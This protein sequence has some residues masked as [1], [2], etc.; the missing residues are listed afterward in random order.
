[1]KLSIVAMEIARHTFRLRGVDHEGRA[2]RRRQVRRGHVLGFSGAW[3]HWLGS[4]RVTS[5]ER[6]ATPPVTLGIAAASS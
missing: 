2:V 4:W 5:V 6:K 3:R 1:M